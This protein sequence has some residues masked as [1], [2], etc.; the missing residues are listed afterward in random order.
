MYHQHNIHGV[1]SLMECYVS[2]SVLVIYIPQIEMLG[3][4]VMVLQ[5]AY[6]AQDTECNL[7]AEDVRIFSI[8]SLGGVMD[9]GA[10]CTHAEGVT[11]TGGQDRGCL[12][13]CPA[14]SPSSSS[15]VTSAVEFWQ[16]IR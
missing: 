3:D 15:H 5:A 4:V 9:A 13:H 6:S 10:L 8:S 1:S 12:L 16:V 2:L 7:K 11:L 14:S